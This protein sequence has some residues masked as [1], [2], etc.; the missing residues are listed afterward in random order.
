MCSGLEIGIIMFEYYCP[1]AGE[2]R[3]SPG[4]AAV[5]RHHGYSRAAESDTSSYVTLTGVGLPVV[6]VTYQV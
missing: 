2:R 6:N 3:V 4:R 1:R 5:R